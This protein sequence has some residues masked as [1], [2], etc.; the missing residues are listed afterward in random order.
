MA[1]IRTHNKQYTILIDIRY[2]FKYTR[3][4]TPFPLFFIYLYKYYNKPQIIN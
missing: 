2:I 1:Q 4:D 3:H